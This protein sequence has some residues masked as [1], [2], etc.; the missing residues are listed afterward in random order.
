M[1]SSDPP[2]RRQHGATTFG[3]SFTALIGPAVGGGANRLPPTLP[4]VVRTVTNPHVH[5]RPTYAIT[6]ATRNA[7]NP[8]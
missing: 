2:T 4:R 1:L 7:G 8:V 3:G 5:S 6:A